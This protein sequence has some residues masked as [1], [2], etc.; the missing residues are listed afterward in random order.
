MNKLYKNE[1]RYFPYQTS[2]GAPFTIPIAVIWC[3]NILAIPKT[4][5]YSYQDCK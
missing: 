2:F 1:N 4:T 5:M 3:N